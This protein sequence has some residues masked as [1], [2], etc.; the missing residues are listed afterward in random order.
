MSNSASRI[1]F[2]DRISGL[3]FS[4][5]F[6]SFVLL[7]FLFLSPGAAAQNSPKPL[8]ASQ[9]LALQ[10]GGALPENLA[11]DIEVR[12]L[13]FHPDEEFVALMKKAGAGAKVLSA[14]SKA[15]M[16]APE[17]VKPDH[18]LLVQ[19]SDAAVLMNKEQYAEA[20]AKLNE[21]LE[22]SFARM[23]TGFVMADL[24]RR[25]EE[26]EKASE[27]Y[28]EILQQ[29]PDFP[30]VHD[31]ASFILYKLGDHE[32]A[33]N[34]AK[35]ALA[36]N[37]NDAEAH[38]NAGLALDEAQR[39][40]AAIAEYKEAL[41]IK[42]DY[43]SA[44]NNLAILF[45]HMHAY[46]DAI[47]EYKKA[48]A[49][50][51]GFALAHY[52]LGIA[53]KEK[54]DL[55]GEIR[56]Y[57][58]AKRLNPND[59]RCRQNLASALMQQDVHAAVLE[60]RELERKF[61]D[62]EMC[63]V[64]LGNALAAENDVDGAEAE[65]RMVIKLSP[66]DPDGHVGL[67]NLEKQEKKYDAAL[68][69]YRVA[70]Q[71]APY[72]PDGFKAA[73]QLLLEK[74]DYAGAVA[75]LKEAEKS[76][77]S[78]WEVHELY[79]RALDATGDRDLA[80]SELKE[81]IALD[82]KQ[83][84]VMTELGAVLEKNGDWVG[85]LEQYRKG[86]L[87]DSARVNKAVLGESVMI[88]EKSPQKEH[89][90]AQKRFEGYVGSLKAS[91]KDDQAAELEKRVQIFENSGS[92]R[93]KEQAAMG[94]GDQAMRSGQAEEAEKSF[95]EAVG[96]AEQLPP[97]DDTL[98]VALGKLGQAYAMRRNLTDADAA[99]HRQLTL[100]EKT[101]GPMSPRMTDPLFFLGMVAA[102]SQNYVS[103]ESYL[104]RSV[105]INVHAFG[106]KSRA[107]RKAS[108]PSRGCIWRRASGTKRKCICCAP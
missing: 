81:A 61:P 85:A 77:P 89:A 57:R 47:A 32:N 73:G 82:P 74:K 4:F 52:N 18:E 15:K 35:A 26:Y 66:A 49:I 8:R 68:E 108:E 97:G 16:T 63:H 72:A 19:L 44:H 75:E 90:A 51:P 10:A 45:T 54:G 55:T 94:A 27:V 102:Q 96:L 12:G 42:P 103:A 95:K 65:Y 64:C 69:E 98:A 37:P 2:S 88:Y 67:G 5:L 20:G 56:E 71:V 1:S 14:L 34:E 3:F 39:F 29:E 86:A 21:A 104:S 30:E 106:E 46:D 92:T 60:L 17:E 84:Q 7:T 36:E 58:E 99:F 40:D 48:I 83:G 79:G 22:R 105:E 11:H 107:P 24:L 80:I 100:I 50:D 38:K 53:Y 78:S 91:G 33:L 101:F 93:E 25:V 59:P 28:A 70:E 9:V 62:F 43:A 31:A 6:L 87:I 23:E 13:S 41:R 76:A